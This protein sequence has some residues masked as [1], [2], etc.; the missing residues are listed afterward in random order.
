MSAVQGFQG[1]RCHSAQQR[2][3]CQGDA[4]QEGVRRRNGSSQVNASTTPGRNRSRGGG[5]FLTKLV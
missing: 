4:L 3:A 2:E 5:I 1:V